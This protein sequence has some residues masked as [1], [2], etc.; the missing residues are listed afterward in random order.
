M[1]TAGR[2]QAD[3]VPIDAERF[4]VELLIQFVK[5]VLI[6]NQRKEEY[7]SYFDAPQNSRR[8]LV[9]KSKTHLVGFTF[10][11]KSGHLN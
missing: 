2:I 9:F 3:V 11:L 10:T 1:V 4:P 7:S 8:A 5:R 6:F